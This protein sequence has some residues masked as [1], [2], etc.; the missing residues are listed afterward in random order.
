MG[1][2]FQIKFIL[3]LG[4]YFYGFLPCA[5][6]GSIGYGDEI[7]LQYSQFCNCHIQAFKITFPLRREN[8]KGKDKSFLGKE[9]LNLH[10]LAPVNV[11]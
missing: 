4:R 6:S 3:D 11:L 9:V 2:H 7:R 1:Q 5:S 8:L 10:A